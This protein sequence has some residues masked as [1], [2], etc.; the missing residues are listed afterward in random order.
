MAWEDWS[1]AENLPISA[2]GASGAIPLKFKDTWRGGIGVHYRL[3]EKWLLKTG[4]VY[5]TSALDDGD[6]T[7]AFPVDRQTR[8][9]VG[10]EYE[11]SESMRVGFAFEWLNLGDAEVNTASVKGDYGPNDLFF[12]G[13]HANWSKLPWSGRG[14]F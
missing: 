3:N 4:F 5:D 1:T 2:G 14:T 7:A 12:F 9:G 8:F 6:R 11:W 10:A 13:I